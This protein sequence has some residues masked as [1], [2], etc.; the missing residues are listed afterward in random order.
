MSIDELKIVSNDFKTLSQL[1]DSHLQKGNLVIL[2]GPTA[3]GKSFTIEKLLQQENIFGAKDRALSNGLNE[4]LIKAKHKWKGR[5]GNK[6]AVDEASYF[7]TGDINQL[8][9]NTLE[10]KV[11]LLLAA[12]NF[13]G[14]FE[15][16]KDYA[17]ENIDRLFVIELAG[18][19]DILQSP[20]WR[21]SDLMRLQHDNF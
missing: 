6:L 13:S 7:K 19:D 20:L 4:F 9:K 8:F 5:T 14:H 17:K 21:E 11:G 12:Q 2:V 1:V 15:C 18:W 10:L 3:T 16:I